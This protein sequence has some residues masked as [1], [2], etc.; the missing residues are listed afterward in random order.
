MVWKRSWPAVSHIC[1]FIFLPLSSTVLILKSIPEN[2]FIYRSLKTNID[3]SYRWILF[4]YHRRPNIFNN[5]WNDDKS[6]VIRSYMWIT[7]QKN[8]RNRVI[9]DFTVYHVNI[10]IFL[11]IILMTWITVAT[12]NLNTKIIKNDL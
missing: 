2:E 5:S 12:V 10:K 8:I 6:G 3:Y 9:H 7:R 11:W 1:S 4:C